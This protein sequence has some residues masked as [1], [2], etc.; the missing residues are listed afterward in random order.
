M[1]YLSS[2]CV[3][4]DITLPISP[5]PQKG[6]QTAAH[7]QKIFGAFL[8]VEWWLCKMNQYMLAVMEELFFIFSKPSFHL[9]LL[10]QN[11]PSHV[12]FSILSFT[13]VRFKKTFLH[14]S[15]LA[16]YHTTQLTFRRIHKFPLQSCEH[17]P[18]RNAWPTFNHTI[19]C[20]KMSLKRKT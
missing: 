6:Q 14:V 9:C 5:S 15:A 18:P 3:S 1:P 13:C 17:H 2:T 11:I 20:D 8:S 19:C 16:K 12:C 10:Q 4:A 7:H